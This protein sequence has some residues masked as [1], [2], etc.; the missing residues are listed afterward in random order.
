MILMWTNPLLIQMA[1][2]SL[3]VI[4]GPKKVWI[5]GPTPSIG[6]NSPFYPPPPPHQATQPFLQKNFEINNSYSVHNIRLRYKIMIV[7]AQVYQYGMGLLSTHPSNCRVINN[8]E[9]LKHVVY[10]VVVSWKDISGA[11]MENRPFPAMRDFSHDG[12]LCTITIQQQL[13]M[14]SVRPVHHSTHHTCRATLL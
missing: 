6:P 5:S 9:D 10:R 12:W 1:L 4:S 7:G 2:A 3:I 13:E 8:F 14:P 11:V